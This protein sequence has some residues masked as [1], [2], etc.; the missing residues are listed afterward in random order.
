MKYALGVFI[1]FPILLFIP[2]VITAM[3]GGSIVNLI[4]APALMAFLLVLL[5]VLVVTGEFKTYVKSVNALFSRKYDISSEDKER[6]IKLFGLMR[7][8]VNYA[9]VFYTTGAIS[10][11]LFDTRNYIYDD[12]FYLGAIGP[13]LSITL[14]LV[15]YA[16]M[17]NLVFILPAI[18]IL[19][20]RKPL[21]EKPV[22][23]NEKEVISKLLELCYKQ[24]ISPEEILNSNE[25]TFH[26]KT[27][28]EL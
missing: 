15:L 9:A 12:R 6:G 4:H 28:K 19:Q 24:G 25:I 8:S 16:V 27:T 14:I 1:L 22:A 3:G 26:N 13:M 5:S 17:I 11:M 10:L 7:K 18:H 21:E 23:I 20:T 2:L